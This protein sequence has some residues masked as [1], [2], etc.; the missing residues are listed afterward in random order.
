MCLKKSSGDSSFMGALV[1]MPSDLFEANILETDFGLGGE[2][3]DTIDCFVNLLRVHRGRTV[4]ISGA[5]LSAHKLPTFRSNNNSGLWDSCSPPSIDSA[6]TYSD[7]KR[8]WR[9]L[10]TI[11]NMQGS[12]ILNP[13]LAHFV[14]HE[15]VD[16]GFLSA[17]ITQNIDG[18]HSFASDLDKVIELHGAVA[19]FGFCNQ[20]NTKRAIDHLR[21]LHHGASPTCE[22]C[23][24]VLK[25]P[26]AFFGDRIDSTKREAARKALLQADLLIVV[27]THCTVDPVL[28][29]VTEAKLGGCLIVEI[30]PAETPASAFA[31]VSLRGTADQIFG[32]VAKMAM[33][34]IDWDAINLEKW[35][36]AR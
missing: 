3:T 20:C 36:C 16:R 7:P 30:N 6:A 4:L 35:D 28:S 2:F 11:R 24:S 12:G 8:C 15:L 19:D 17:V 10:A 18:L 14:I 25:P 31:D 33:D 34:D 5:G 22:V 13:S 23:G 27:G 32:D 1:A 29:M 26:V 9:L 21:V